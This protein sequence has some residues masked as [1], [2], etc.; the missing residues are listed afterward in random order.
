KYSYTYKTKP[1]KSDG[2]GE[3]WTRG[4]VLG[5]ST[6]VNGMM[7]TR[8]FQADYDRLVELGNPGWGWDHILPAY[9]KREDHQLGA[10]DTRG[11][12]GPYG[13]SIPDAR[14][15]VTEALFAAARNYGWKVAVRQYGGTNH[16]VGVARRRHDSRGG[17]RPAEKEVA[18]DS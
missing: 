16:G 17:V 1:F 10:S 14:D 4:K 2:T 18:G 8:G 13:V 15:E 3:G 11:A 5:G 12:G 6:T 9:K 7:Y